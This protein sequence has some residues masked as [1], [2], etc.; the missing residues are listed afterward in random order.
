[1]ILRLYLSNF[2]SEH[3]AELGLGHGIRMLGWL[4][5]KVRFVEIKTKF[6]SNLPRCWY[7]RLVF[8]G[9]SK[10]ARVL[11]LGRSIGIAE[12]KWLVDVKY[13]FVCFLEIDL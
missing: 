3:T 9:S 10:V 1:M 8:G 5:I 2:T 4:G 12:I 6:G 13:L 11:L 7:C